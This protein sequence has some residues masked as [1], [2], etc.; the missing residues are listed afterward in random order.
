MH[1]SMLMHIRL[2]LK[3]IR[4]ILMIMIMTFSEST[5][6]I[7]DIKK[8]RYIIRLIKKEKWINGWDRMRFELWL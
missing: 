8:N 6:N 1:C 7:W 4:I 3:V 2:N 5:V